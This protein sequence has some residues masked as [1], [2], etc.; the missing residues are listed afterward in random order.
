VEKNTSDHCK[1]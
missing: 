1:K